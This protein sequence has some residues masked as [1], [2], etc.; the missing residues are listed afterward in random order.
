MPKERTVETVIDHIDRNRDRYVRELIEL[1]KIPSIS[2]SSKHRLD[3]RRCAEYLQHELERIGVRKTRL[4][5]TDGHP[6]VYAEWTE[7]AGAPTVLI[8][9]HYDVQ[10][11]D[12]LD[13]W[14]TPPFEPDVRNGRLYG[15][16]TV[17]DKG[18]VFAH[19]KAVEAWLQQT[20]TLPL[21][22]KFLF[23]GEEEIGSANL[24]GFLRDNAALVRS[25]CVVVSDTPM[26]ARGLP[27]ICYGLRGLAY[28]QVDVRACASDLHS[29]SFGGV[30]GN[31][32]HAL[33]H[34]LDQL[35]DQSGRI[36]VPGFYDKV[37]PLESD[38]RAALAALPFVEQQVL[39]DTGA[40]A[41]LGEE[42]YTTLERLWA[43]PTLDLNGIW[44]GFI[45]EGAKT[46]IPATAHAK[47]SMR[48]VPEQDPAVISTAAASYL[49]SLAPAWATVDV[50]VL[51]GGQ[52]WY[53]PHTDPT[54]DLAAAALCKGFGVERIAYIREG[55]SIPF[56][57]TIADATHRPCLLIGFGLP[58]ECAHAPNEWLDLDNYHKGIRSSA[59][60]Y[61]ELSQL[62][63]LG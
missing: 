35:K 42:G 14:V 57:R 30:I 38:E 41:L 51:H 29:G 61:D 36:R 39:T 58:D 32:L 18:Q 27:S 24:D 55:G 59:Y 56:V 17:D 16:G 20:G 8:Y 33:V 34:I 15:R 50:Q 12:P 53:D 40:Q 37:L 23:E 9:G 49:R 48:L 45:E 54:F 26:L 19:L 47:L 3:V 4:F 44:G 1:V 52:S 31:P 25:D 5:E 46:V 10:P 28:L 2:S 63:T 6:V 60:L 43:R 7:N 13:Q 22:L 11:V 62:P 21:N